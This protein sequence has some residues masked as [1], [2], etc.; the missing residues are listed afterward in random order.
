MGDRGRL[1]GDPVSDLMTRSERA[2]QQA[3][4]K[5]S[6]ALALAQKAGAL[7]TGAGAVRCAGFRT[8]SAHAA[9]REVGVAGTGGDR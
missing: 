7:A 1:G 2:G 4:Q 6:R 5:E 3:Q 8:S 9:E